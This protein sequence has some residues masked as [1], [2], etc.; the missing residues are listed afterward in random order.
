MPSEDALI[1]P[2]PWY[3]YVQL[4]GSNGREERKVTT[5]YQ[6]AKFSLSSYHGIANDPSFV[7]TKFPANQ[8][9]HLEVCSPSL[10]HQLLPICLDNVNGNLSFESLVHGYI[11]LKQR[12]SGPMANAE[13]HLLVHDFLSSPKMYDGINPELIFRQTGLGGTELEKDIQAKRIDLGLDNLDFLFIL[14]QARE[15]SS[16]Q[17]MST[18]R[19]VLNRL[20]SHGD[21][22]GL[23][24]VCEPL[25]ATGKIEWRH[26]DELLLKTLRTGNFEV[27]RYILDLATRTQPPTL[28]FLGHHDCTF[29]PLY[30]TIRLGHLETTEKLL[31]LG[32]TFDGFCRVESSELQ[33]GSVSLNPLTAATYWGQ[34]H[35]IRLLLRRGL[36]TQYSVQDAID[37]AQSRGNHTILQELQ[38]TSSRFQS[39]PELS[40]GVAFSTPQTISDVSRLIADAPTSLL[41][42]SRV[43]WD[44]NSTLEPLPRLRSN[45][46]ASGLSNRPLPFEDTPFQVVSNGYLSTQTDKTT[47]NTTNPTNQEFGSRL[48]SAL[49][50]MCFQV[51]SHAFQI[52]RPGLAEK[53]RGFGRVW[54]RGMANIRLVTQ[55]K[56]PKSLQAVLDCLLAAAAITKAKDGL[57]NR[58]FV[59]FVSDLDCW[60]CV[61]PDKDR[62]AFDSFVHSVWSPPPGEVL[63]DWN[64]ESHIT[65]QRFHGIL[66]KFVFDRDSDFSISLSDASAQGQVFDQA[67]QYASSNLHHDYSSQGWA[68]NRSH[69]SRRSLPQTS[70]DAAWADYSQT[71]A[72][73]YMDQHG[74]VSHLTSLGNLDEPPS[75][76]TST[77]NGAS[78]LTRKL[79]GSVAISVVFSMLIV[80]QVGGETPETRLIG[81]QRYSL[82]SACTILSKYT[83]MLSGSAAMYHH[84]L[85]TIVTPSADYLAVPELGAPTPSTTVSSECP[86]PSPI[87]GTPD[88]AI[89]QHVPSPLLSTL[90]PLIQPI[91]TGYITPE[92]GCS[93]RRRSPSLQ[94]ERSVNSP[95]DDKQTSSR[96]RSDPCG[97]CG[98]TFSSVTNLRKHLRDKIDIMLVLIYLEFLFKI[99]SLQ[100]NKARKITPAKDSSIS[101]SSENSPPVATRKSKLMSLD[102]NQDTV[103]QEGE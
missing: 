21:V 88:A 64:Q 90:S 84:Q 59:N 20:V 31:D 30:V 91:S 70:G 53:F 83:D 82:S 44:S 7:V 99:M 13:V 25:V 28:V 77:G 33:E 1:E 2:R 12:A 26:N 38:H 66:D 17:Y 57:K 68:H 47:P 98:R 75:V 14:G 89:L 36:A 63:G 34:T 79:M 23:R 69:P 5:T 3:R 4:F 16:P 60:R 24:R 27:L 58:A 48:S 94:S 61:V 18:F 71:L 86:T 35:V 74:M 62:P 56:P 95:P 19:R 29:N 52:G 102:M 73:E 9:F 45:S 40:H 96:Q 81:Q 55:N 103:L 39:Q 49:Q 93:P 15:A 67:T 8:T 51:Q 43:D 32:E 87:L 101:N 85:P 6:P 100:I 97:S 80:I 76:R 65:V 37:V 22:D 10:Q 92:R 11:M 72:V 41:Q 42:S 78:S 50:T 46:A 54:E